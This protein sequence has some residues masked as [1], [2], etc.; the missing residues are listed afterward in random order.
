MYWRDNKRDKRNWFSRCTTI[1]TFVALSEFWWD[2]YYLL[3]QALSGLFLW[4]K[5]SRICLFQLF[6]GERYIWNNSISIKV[7]FCSNLMFLPMLLII[8]YLVIVCIG[9]VPVW[10]DQSQ[11]QNRSEVMWLVLISSGLTLGSFSIPAT[12]SGSDF[13]KRK[14]KVGPSQTLKH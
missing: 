14:E 8:I 7:R 6:K 9:P 13:P 2:W 3:I 1:N 11:L 10:T 12:S 5:Y 4:Y